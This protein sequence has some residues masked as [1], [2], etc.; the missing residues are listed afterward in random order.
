M[1]QGIRSRLFSPEFSP[2]NDIS[3][4]FEPKYGRQSYHGML[5]LDYG[6]FDLE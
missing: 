5:D 4:F 3:H 2:E 1:A 6:A